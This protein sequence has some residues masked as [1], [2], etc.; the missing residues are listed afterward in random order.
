MS[1]LPRWQTVTGWVLTTLVGLFLLLDS[2]MKLV[3]ARVAVE[4]T[5]QL[6]F[7]ENTI[8]GTGVALLVCTVLYLVPLTSPLGAVLITGYLGGAVASI[9]RTSQNFVFPLVFAVFVWAGLLLR[10]ERS[11]VLLGANFRQPPE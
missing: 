9:V 6:G 10:S 3:K 7:P 1:G 2:G 8:V 11:R 4:G 5:V